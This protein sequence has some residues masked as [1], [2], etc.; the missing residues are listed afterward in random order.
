MRSAT[1]A[2]VARL[3]A[4]ALAL[5]V[6]LPS[7]ARAATPVM[8]SHHHVVDVQRLGAEPDIKIDS[9]GNVTVHAKAPVVPG[10]A[11]TVIPT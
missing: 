10:A 1:L 9:A 7:G 3:T 4:I 11:T 5:T 2:G 6:A 8:F